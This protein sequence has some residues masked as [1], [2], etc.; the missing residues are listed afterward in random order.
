MNTVATII[1]LL[2]CAVC[3]IV[4]LKSNKCPNCGDIVYKCDKCNEEW[5]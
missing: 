1:I 3:L 5:I 2:I 4:G